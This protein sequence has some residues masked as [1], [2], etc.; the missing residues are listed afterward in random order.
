MVQKVNKVKRAT[1]WISNR[2]IHQSAAS[3]PMSQITTVT[4]MAI[5]HA[6]QK[7]AERIVPITLPCVTTMPRAWVA[8]TTVLIH[9]TINATTLMTDSQAAAPKLVGQ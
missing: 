6:A 3:A 8:L 2:Q 5:H 4:R 9:Q 7:T 1:H